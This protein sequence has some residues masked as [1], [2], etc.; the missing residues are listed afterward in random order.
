MMEN[1]TYRHFSVHYLPYLLLLKVN[2]EVITGDEY[3]K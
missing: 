1:F 3:S 2:N